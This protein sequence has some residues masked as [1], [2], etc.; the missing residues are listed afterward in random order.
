M[1]EDSVQWR[2][3]LN[4]TLNLRLPFYWSGRQLSASLEEVCSVDLVG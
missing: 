3:T 1:A 4:T 2:A